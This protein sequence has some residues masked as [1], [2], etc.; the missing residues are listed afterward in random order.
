MIFEV[1]RNYHIGKLVVSHDPSLVLAVVLLH[2]FMSLNEIGTFLSLVF[3][4]M[5]PAKG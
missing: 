1:V 5:F 4:G 2:E 3:R